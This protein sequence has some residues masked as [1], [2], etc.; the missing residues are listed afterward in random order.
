MADRSQ[1]E[2]AFR[3]IADRLDRLAA[4]G[5]PPRT[6]DRTIVCRIPDLGTAF[7]GELRD[8]CLRDLGEGHRDD[9]QITLTVNSDDL[10]AV[11]EGRLSVLSAW[12]S[13]RLKVDASV[14]DLLRVRSLL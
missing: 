1:C 14:R 5:R 9:A 12:T 10:I 3:S 6:P 7:S 8:G 13:G 2:T 4:E 11:T